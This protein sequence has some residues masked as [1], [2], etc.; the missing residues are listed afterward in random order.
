LVGYGDWD[1]TDEGCGVV[2][3]LDLDLDGEPDTWF[4]D[5]DADGIND[6]LFPFAP[7]HNLWPMVINEVGQVLAAQYVNGSYVGGYLLTPDY[8]DADGDGNPWFADTN[9]DGYNDLLVAL[10][11]PA[12]G[13]SF[14]VVDLNNLGQVAG[15]SGGHAVRWDFTNGVQTVT[16]LGTLADK[17]SMGVGGISDSGRMAGYTREIKG[18]FHDYG[19]SW[20]IENNTLYELLPLLINPPG[21]SSLNAYGINRNDWILGPGFVAIPVQQP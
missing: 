6:L 13:M 1:Q 19:P 16:D 12:P 2:V 9:S 17:W 3:P 14:Q 20:L 8:S 5:V 11:P 18:R 7:E 10:E 21:W 4:T 15:Q